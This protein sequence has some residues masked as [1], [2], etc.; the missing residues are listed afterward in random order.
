MEPV[1]NL[2]NYWVMELLRENVISFVKA[3]QLERIYDL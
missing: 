1:E 2:Y 3:H